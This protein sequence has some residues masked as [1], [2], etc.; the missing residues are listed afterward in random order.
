MFSKYRKSSAGNSGQTPELTAIDG[1]APNTPATT[2]FDERKPLP[3][4]S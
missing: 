3:S 2:Q 1:G 4:V